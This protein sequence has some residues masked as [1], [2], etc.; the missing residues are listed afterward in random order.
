M[1]KSRAVLPAGL[2]CAKRPSRQGGSGNL[3]PTLVASPRVGPA[4]AAGKTRVV[5]NND[6]R[7]VDLR[8]EPIDQA[9]VEPPGERDTADH[10]ADIA[11]E[12]R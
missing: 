5:L 3:V 1:E 8:D 6:K 12:I 10:A 2:G 11:S 7:L 4:G 9:N